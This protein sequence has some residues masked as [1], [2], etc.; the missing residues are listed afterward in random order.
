MAVDLVH[1]MVAQ[2]LKEPYSVRKTTTEQGRVAH[3]ADLRA[4]KMEKN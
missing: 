3:L 4:W 1:L 2:I